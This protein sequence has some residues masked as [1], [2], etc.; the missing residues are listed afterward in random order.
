MKFDIPSFEKYARDKERNHVDNQGNA[1][2]DMRV[3]DRYIQYERDRNSILTHYREFDSKGFLK[4]EGQL[5]RAGGERAMI[6]KW[7]TYDSRGRVVDTIDH[8]KGYA[9]DLRRVIEICATKHINLDDRL[10]SLDRAR[11]GEKPTWIVSYDSGRPGSADGSARYI[12]LISIDGVT[13]ATSELRGHDH[14]DN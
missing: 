2:R 6:G 12:N 14:L 13:G 9:V 4:R 10:S 5:A 7:N 3:G 1:F 8:E 11:I